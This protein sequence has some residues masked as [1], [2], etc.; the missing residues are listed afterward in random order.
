MRNEKGYIER[1]DAAGQNRRLIV[2]RDDV[3]PY[4]ITQSDYRLFWMQNSSVLQLNISSGARTTLHT[5]AAGISSLMVVDSAKQGGWNGCVMNNTCQYLCLV[6][7]GFE[8]LSTETTCACSTHH[9]MVDGFCR[10][11]DNFLLYAQR[12]TLSRLITRTSECPDFP[13][14]YPGKR[15]GL[16]GRLCRVMATYSR[17]WNPPPIKFWLLKTSVRF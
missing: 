9:T 11:P 1:C 12:N 15:P 8:P 13:L 14:M 4:S 2:D 3:V 5:H 6:R 16:W 7:P 17:R 10:P